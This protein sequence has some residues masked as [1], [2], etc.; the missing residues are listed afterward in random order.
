M[1][2][3]SRRKAKTAAPVPV[4]T[5][6]ES[7]DDLFADVQKLWLE[8]AEFF[9]ALPAQEQ[10]E[11]IGDWNIMRDIASKQFNDGKAVSDAVIRITDAMRLA[12][13]ARQKV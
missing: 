1:T 10:Q 3:L 9:D 2:E 5:K 4:N 11:F 6:P 7:N 12:L 13:I 8:L